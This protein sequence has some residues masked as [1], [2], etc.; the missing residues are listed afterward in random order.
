[1]AQ[2]E[3][4][5]WGRVIARAW[6]DPE[7]KERLLRDPAR[8]LAEQGIEIRGTVHIHEND[9]DAMHVVIPLPPGDLDPTDEDLPR[10][11]GFCCGG[12]YCCC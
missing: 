7:F 9:D 6:A 3:R 12:T 5:R 4:A 2:D 8:V 10:F 1:M 11:E